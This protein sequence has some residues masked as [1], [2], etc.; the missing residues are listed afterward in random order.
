MKTTITPNAITLAIFTMSLSPLAIMAKAS[1]FIEPPMVSIAAGSFYM[2]S[3]RGEEN[4]KPVRKVSVPAFQMGKYEVTVAE[5]K[6]FIADTDYEM[7]DNCYQYVLGGPNRELASWKDTIYNVSDNHPVVCLPQKAAVAYAEWLSKKT[8]K[9]YRLPTE[10]QWEYTL[11]AGTSTQHFF[12]EEIDKAKACQYANISDWYAKDIA[13]KGLTGPNVRDVEQ[14]SDNEATLATVGLYQANPFGVYDMVGNAMEYL[15]DCYVDN[16]KGAPIDGSAVTKAGCDEFVARG[17]SWHWYPFPSSQ[18]GG[19]ANDFLGALEGFRLVLDTVGKALPAQTGNKHF[20]KQLKVAQ[21]KAKKQHAKNPAYPSKPTGLKVL[22]A[23]KNQVTLSW[24]DN[25]EK[26]LSGYT[27]YRQDPITNKKVAIATAVNKSYFV[28][29]SP[30]AHNGRYSVVALNNKTASQSSDIIDSGFALLHT[31]PMKIQGEAFRQAKE[32]KVR[33]S[34]QEPSDD[35][36]F[37]SLGASEAV[38]KIKVRKSGDYTVNA[39]VYHAGEAQEFEFWLGDKKI[40]TSA[41]TGESG[42]Q[43]INNIAIDL[44]QGIH[45]L[46]VKGKQPRFAINWLDVKAT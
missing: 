22:A 6:K 45:N 23:N 43:T 1:S 17:G 5:F 40:A 19:I 12:G 37:A 27:V 3:D 25:H 4:E 20:I 36:I 13:V 42:W 30:L 11:R 35:K 7:P 2:G 31:L 34:V 26:I 9:N 14:C 32:A 39:R 18:R 28:D 46:T 29:N 15:A 10:A 8:G 38:Y 16:Y 21:N 33:D 41:I 24:N 44:P